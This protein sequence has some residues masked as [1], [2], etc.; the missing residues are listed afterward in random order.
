MSL[1]VT[2]GMNEKHASE[3]D[4]SGSAVSI[5]QFPS[6]ISSLD[7]FNSLLIN[8][9]ITSLGLLKSILDIATKLIF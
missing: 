6:I 2:E 3:I 7:K 5:S 9:R 4:G 1:S 8:L